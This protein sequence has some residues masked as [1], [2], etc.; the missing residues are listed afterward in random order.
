M[1]DPWL[2]EDFLV[3]WDGS[4]GHLHSAVARDASDEALDYAVLIR[5]IGRMD[6]ELELLIKPFLDS[7]VPP[8]PALEF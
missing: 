2:G 5:H 7:V 8:V 4:I 6:T 3:F 1:G